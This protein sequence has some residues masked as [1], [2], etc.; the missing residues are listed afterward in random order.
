MTVLAP[1]V[2][3]PGPM[4]SPLSRAQRAHWRMTWGQ[5]LA[6]N[7]RLT[8]ALPV[9]ITVYGLPIVFAQALGLRAA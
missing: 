2:S 4:L 5:R 8:T 3:P 9:E 1:P 7:A 6:R